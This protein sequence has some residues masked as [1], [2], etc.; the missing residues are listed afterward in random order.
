M[1]GTA[2]RSESWSDPRVPAADVCV[3]RYVLGKWAKMQPAKDYAV[4]TNQRAWSYHDTLIRAKATASALASLGV[5]QGDHVACWL[6]IGADALQ[7]ML[8]INYLGAVYVPFNTAY[9]GNLLAHVIAN[10]GAQ[11]LIA[12]A[13][14]LHQ[15][16]TVDTA[17]LTTVISLSDDH[18]AAR[19]NASELNCIDREGFELYGV[20]PPPLTRPICP[21]DMQSII[22]TSGTTGPSK[23]VMSSYLHA[24][25][26]MGPEA[27][28]VIQASD[29]YLITLPMFHIGGSFICNIMLCHDGSVA[30]AGDFRTQDFWP[31][32]R[33]TE[34]TVVFLLGVMATFITKQAPSMTDAQNSLRSVFVVPLIDNVQGF[35]VRFGVDVYTIFN[36]TEVAT[37]TFSAINPAQAG[38]CGVAREGVELRLVDAFDCEVPQGKVGE[39]IV[40]TDRPWA[41]THGYHKNP[42]ATLAAWRN[43][44]FHTGDA[45]R[46]DSNGNFYFVDRLKDAIRR[47]GENISSF[48]VEVEAIAHAH[49]REAAAIPV[50]NELGDD[51]VMLVVAT[52]GD[53]QLSPRSLFDFLVPR[54]ATYMLP[55][56]IEVVSTLPKTPTAKVQK[57]ILRASGVSPKTWDRER[58]GIHVGRSGI[59]YNTD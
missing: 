46:Q 3:L 38:T 51:D 52:V 49:V 32:V 20:E 22:Y 8:G 26:N 44:W 31:A 42:E 28:P 7:A 16:D 45:F 11:I 9:K 18:T 40:R 27:W 55:R 6:P 23:G 48:E 30:M 39:M 15:L 25:S 19:S 50:A 13:S 54:M 14:L 10:S 43:G 57:H 17:Q 53:T 12:H 36:M 5:R 24:Y 29:R 56:F 37:P 41:M 4:F 1:R 33:K 58:A 34:A 2:L 47:R 35:A 59:T 21:W